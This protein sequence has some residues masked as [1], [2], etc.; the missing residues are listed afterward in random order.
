MQGHNLVALVTVLSLILLIV[1]GFR[2]GRARGKFGV[3]A[4]ATTGHD[5]FERHFRVQMNTLEQI[6][7]FLPS[8]WLFS[9]YWS[10]Y[11][12]AALGAVWIVARLLYMFGYVADPKRREVGFILGALPT[13]ILL[14][15]A[16]V[17]AVHALIVTGGV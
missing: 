4:P 6:V 2:V 10:Q 9:F 7:V 15:G 1:A 17:G 12:A 3:A 14:L 11:V 5:I 13:V 16:G 8:L